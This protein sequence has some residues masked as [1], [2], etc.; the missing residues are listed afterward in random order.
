M[1]PYE[2]FSWIFYKFIKPISVWL[3][4]NFLEPPMKVDLRTAI[5]FSGS[6]SLTVFFLCMMAT[7]DTI[8]VI[9]AT[10]IMGLC[11]QGFTKFL[12]F[13][14]MNGTLL[15]SVSF[16]ERIY[17]SNRTPNQLRYQM[18]DRCSRF[19][20]Q[21]CRFFIRLAAV[22]VVALLSAPVLQYWLTGRSDAPLPIYVPFVDESSTKGYVVNMGYSMFLVLLGIVGS[23]GA[24][25]MQ[26][27]LVLHMWPMSLIFGDMIGQLSEAVLV[28]KNR[29]SA[30]LRVFLRKILIM[31]QQICRWVNEI[32]W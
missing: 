18:L 6:T 23:L 29:D 15:E 4:L 31:H 30:N 10:T 27:M 19:F 1:E 14:L 12:T 11:L 5:H 20:H 3:G 21:L 16:I 28:E 17:K 13:Y 26:I 7:R 9:K 22:N 25:S 32:V 24:D 8:T 2:R